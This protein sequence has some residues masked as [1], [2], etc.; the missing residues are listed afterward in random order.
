MMIEIIIKKNTLLEREER[1]KMNFGLASLNCFESS[2]AV[3]MGLAV[4][5][6]PPVINNY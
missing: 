5:T 2:S 6:T 1:V 4:V 3:E